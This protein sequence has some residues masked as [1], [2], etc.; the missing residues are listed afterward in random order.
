MA[1]N[2]YASPPA[3]NSKTRFWN[4][5]R[6]GPKPKPRRK[7]HTSDSALHLP[8]SS[9]VT[10]PSGVPRSAGP[11]TTPTLKE[12]FEPE[13]KYASEE[14]SL[15]RFASQYQNSLPQQVMVT[16]G[17]YW[18]EHTEVN[19]SNSEKLNVY[20]VRHRESVSKSL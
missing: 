15:S 12:Q 7:R 6:S 9:D 11:L 2:T 4:K 16:D 10:L 8:A 17:V 14:M 1:T 13:I 5:I 20:F 19:I 18:K 3:G